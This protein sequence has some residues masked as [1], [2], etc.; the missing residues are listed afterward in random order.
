MVSSLPAGAA[1]AVAERAD[2]RH[3]RA[4]ARFRLAGIAGIVLGVGY[5]VFVR[6]YQAA[7]GTIGL[8]GPRPPGL[9]WASYTAGVAILVGAAACAVLTMP[10]LRTVPAWSP[11]AR[12]RRAP[13]WA[14]IAFCAVPALGA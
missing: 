5:A 8:D 9:S 12:G 3:A 4:E 10:S 6:F 7:G 11:I 1:A 14:V 13:R 2:V